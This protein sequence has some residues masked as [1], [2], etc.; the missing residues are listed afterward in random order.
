MVR[1]GTATTHVNN[2]NHWDAET[3]WLLHHICVRLLLT[4]PSPERKIAQHL[5][6]TF[7]ACLTTTLDNPIAS[8]S[9][10]AYWTLPV[11]RSACQ[12]LILA[13]PWPADAWDELRRNKRG[14]TNWRNASRCQKSIQRIRMGMAYWHVCG[15]GRRCAYHQVLPRNAV[16]F[17]TAP[18]F[19]FLI[20]IDNVRP[21]D[22][23]WTYIQNQ[24]R[25]HVS[26]ECS[27]ALTWSNH[28]YNDLVPQATLPWGT[29][30]SPDPE[31]IASFNHTVLHLVASPAGTPCLVSP[32]HPRCP[33][34]PVP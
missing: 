7:P 32:S 1:L 24:M 21:W 23:V 3:Q 30:R 5:L 10:C 31:N 25:R 29:I 14:S 6:R 26:M 8:E 33:G 18:L 20:V 4:H 19:P 27:G 13:S 17:M 28:S 2:R 16:N 11:A 34:Q 9:I 22:M 12:R 15:C